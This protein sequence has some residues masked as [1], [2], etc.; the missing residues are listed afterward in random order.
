M[1]DLFRFFV[2]RRPDD[3]EPHAAVPLLQQ[4]PL[5][6]QLALAR[7]SAAPLDAMRK[8][9]EEYLQSQQSVQ[10]PTSLQFGEGLVQFVSGI[11]PAQTADQLTALVQHSFGEDASH[12]TRS[13]DFA[14]DEQ[15][16]SDTLLSL[17][18]TSEPGGGSGQLLDLY[19][20]VQLIRLLADSAQSS[21]ISS[22]AMSA[23]V[24]LPRQLFPLPVTPIQQL[25]PKPDPNQA[26][27]EGEQAALVQ[28]A[29]NLADALRALSF[30]PVSDLS[31]AV[32]PP[33]DAARIA[34][35][36]PKQQAVARPPRKSPGA[37]GEANITRP[38]ALP[39][40][41]IV[42]THPILEQLSAAVKATI[43]D[44]G[45]DVSRLPLGTLTTAV[46][47]ELARVISQISNFALMFGIAS[48][49]EL[50]GLISLDPPA[51][52]SEPA[53]HDDA[54]DP[55]PDVL[56]GPPSSHGTVQPA[57]VADLLV[58]REHVLRYEPGEVAYVENVAA[59][60]DFQRST[61]RTNT[62]Q[63][64][65]TT[66]Q[67]TS[68]T[69]ERDTQAT[70]RFDLNRQTNSV[71]QA[72]YAQIPG[73]PSSETYGPLVQ[74][75]GSKQDANSTATSFGQDVTAR[76]A[77]QIAEQF[78]TET[79][80]QTTNTFEEDITHHFDN[81]RGTNNRVIVYQWLDKIS[82][83]Q[84]FTYGKRTMYEVNIP[85][86][87]TFLLRSLAHQQPDLLT[88]RKPLPFT[89]DP[90]QLGRINYLYYAAAYGATGIQA[91]PDPYVGKGLVWPIAPAANNSTI[92]TTQ[93]ELV[94]IP[95]GY[96]AENVVATVMADGDFDIR[97]TVG[98]G[99][100][101]QSLFLFNLG[102]FFQSADLKNLEG[103]IPVAA[104]IWG[105]G[106][107][108]ITVEIVCV[109]SD[110]SWETWQLNTHQAILQASRDRI[111]EYEQKWATLQAALKILTFGQSATRKRQIERTE[112]KKSALAVLTGQQFD[113]LNAIEHS[114]EGY[115]QPFLPNM[116]PVGRYVRF[117]EEA[118]EWD[119]MMYFYYPYF[120]G[121]KPYWVDR[122]LLEDSDDQFGDFLRAGSAR[123][124]I[125]VRRGFEGAVSAFMTNGTVPTDE[126]LW[127]L[128]TTENLPFLAETLGDT[129]GP[130]TATPYSPPW[131]VRLPTTLTIVRKDASFP[132]WK[133]EIDGV[134][135]AVWV[136]DV[137]DPIG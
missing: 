35:N 33:P 27:T 126:E 21:Q 81:S 121:R 84:V 5:A 11:G 123:V 15:R 55:P 76:A 22:A 87:A 26:K 134:G 61:K 20:A 52:T 71:L 116:E 67:S 133:Q 132:K 32:P 3:P 137:S 88:L 136:S 77:T 92:N 68:S 106:E 47:G 18:I 117:L 101:G 98:E 119:Q 109:L 2:M 60:E 104:A 34:L 130:D 9:A 120:W 111:A 113:G 4:T 62:T 89:L 125:P 40:G 108:T 7:A 41:P 103:E 70:S 29:N 74:S 39:A 83:A 115:P 78:R 96:A 100:A 12:L 51:P 1:N 127:Q 10:S 118:F 99:P 75:G 107:C 85:E 45:P 14:A 97:V 24:L 16:L 56:S 128:T 48:G 44:L 73:A 93:G 135:R 79:V 57:G 38:P 124:I 80:T 102:S 105:I 54:S 19:R 37:T 72:D 95:P 6:N 42:G 63:T 90:G 8:A 110:N 94:A 131:E 66:E 17:S 43:T 129:G 23:L 82:Q 64:T 59:G 25:P 13:R 53:K 31:D 122:V 58:V 112:L 114:A 86:P 91:P 50:G 65:I 30:L 46:R 69:Q 36:P 49:S 28:R